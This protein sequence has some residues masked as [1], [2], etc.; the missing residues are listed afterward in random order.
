MDN[1]MA[2]RLCSKLQSDNAF[3]G[4]S[5]DRK[6]EGRFVKTRYLDG[7]GGQVHVGPKR[8]WLQ[9][10]LGAARSSRLSS[11][12]SPSLPILYL[13]PRLSASTSPR[14][15]VSFVVIKGNC[16]RNSWSLLARRTTRQTERIYSAVTLNSHSRCHILCHA[17]VVLVW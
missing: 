17:H 4:A 8:P 15:D 13:I 3:T 12:P 9:N 10:V 6:R 11:S 16:T 14:Y 2:G 1:Q 7:A 5:A